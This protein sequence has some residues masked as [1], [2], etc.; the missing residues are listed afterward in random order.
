MNLEVLVIYDKKK[1]IFLHDIVEVKKCSDK[2][3]IQF[4]SGQKYLYGMDRLIVSE[5]YELIDSFHRVMINN[6][7]YDDVQKIYYHPELNCYKFYLSGNRV[8]IADENDVCLNVKSGNND[9]FL[10]YLRELA[11][12]SKMG[13][14]EESFLSRQY[15]KLSGIDRN[16]VFYSYMNGNISKYN[17]ENNSLIYPFGFNQ[18]QRQAVQN[19]FTA[20]ISIIEGPPGT[21]KTQTI[22]NIIANIIL[23]KKT[24]A[25]VS[26]NNAAI[27]NVQE[28]LAKRQ[29]IKK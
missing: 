5:Q 27:L 3:E 22:L 9:R 8:S 23:Q 6:R 24:V 21:G 15:N 17:T 26:N 28:K 4:N 18:S 25:V 29:F 2:Y 19:A 16:S 14:E 12:G 1:N 11:A 20:N 7:I 10:P 13:D